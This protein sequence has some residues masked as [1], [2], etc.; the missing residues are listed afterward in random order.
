MARNAATGHGKAVENALT[1]S[2]TD[3]AILAEL[4]SD[5]FAS[6]ASVAKALGLATSLVSSRLRILQRDRVS[7]V[8]AVIDL[9]RINQSFCFVQIQIKG[10]SVTEVAEE[11]AAQRLVLMVSELAD[12]A[13]DLLALVRFGDIHSLNEVICR[14]LATIEGVRTWKIDTV[15]DV[16]VFRAEYISYSPHYTPLSFEDN[17]GY[18]KLDIPEGMCD[19]IDLQIIAHLQENAHQSINDISRKLDMKPS[20]ARYRINNLKSSEIIRF[21]RVIDQSAVGIDTFTFVEINVELSQTNSVIKALRDQQWLPQLFRCV[22][23]VD[24][25]GIMVTNGTDEVL[26][27]KREILSEIDGVEAVKISRLHKTHKNDLRW[28]QRS[29]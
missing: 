22:G 16:P 1:L 26:R 20:T 25:V 29:T 7:Q 10:R 11:M 23:S 5:P 13:W 12:G 21:I 28:A 14:D 4:T 2:D 18:L 19:E 27:L 15:V 6:N 9:D 3:Q 24:L 17:V 8:L